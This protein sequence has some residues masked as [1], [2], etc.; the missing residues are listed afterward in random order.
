MKNFEEVYSSF[1]GNFNWFVLFG[2]VVFSAAR[3]RPLWHHVVGGGDGFHTWRTSVG[4][5]LV[6]RLLPVIV[7]ENTPYRMD[8]YDY[9]VMYPIVTCFSLWKIVV[10]FRKKETDHGHHQ[11]VFN[12]AD[13]RSAHDIWC[14]CVCVRGA[15]AETR[16]WCAMVTGKENQRY[17]FKIIRIFYN[18]VKLL[19]KLR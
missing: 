7:T 16:P 19:Y 5:V 4:P 15:C 18:S 11:K 12:M 2:R 14:V 17:F 10:L 3:R 1:N 13:G 6:R 8:W 9:I